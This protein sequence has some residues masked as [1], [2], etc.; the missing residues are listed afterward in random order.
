MARGTKNSLSNPTT[1][2]SAGISAG[3]ATA[4]VVITTEFPTGVT[5]GVNIGNEAADQEVIDCSYDGTTT[6]T[7]VGTAAKDHDSGDP[8]NIVWTE[9]DYTNFVKKDSDVDTDGTLA[10][11]SDSKVATQKATKTYADLKAD[12]DDARFPT[13]DEKA[14]LT[15]ALGGPLSPSN[16]VVSEGSN[17][18]PIVGT[19]EADVTVKATAAFAADTTFAYFLIAADG[20]LL[21]IGA[22][23]T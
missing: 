12:E 10:A 22:G 13:A 7:F 19:D 17:R 8:V 11:N 16:G 14:G 21:D 3:A 5:F 2:L 6:I 9:N 15:N 1:T 23:I 4:P 18:V 20:T